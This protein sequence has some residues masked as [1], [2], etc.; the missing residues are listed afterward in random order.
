MIRDSGLPMRAAF[1]IWLAM[2]A[3]VG[4]HRQSETR[5][6]DFPDSNEVTGWTRTGIIR[7]FSADD[8]WKYIDGE[9]ERY[10]KAGVQGVST[11]DYKFQGKLD[12]VVDIYAM[13]TESGAE[14]IFQSEPEANSQSARLGDNA[15]VYS[16]SLVFRKGRYLVRITAYQESSETQPA[17]LALAR[18][19][20]QR[21]S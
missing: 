16:Q 4:C 12:A 3:I 13:T 7:A 6:V 5:K 17:L 11:A 14:K 19:V 18:G 10:L 2:I 20:E 21:L 1:T 8:L 9:A 15:R